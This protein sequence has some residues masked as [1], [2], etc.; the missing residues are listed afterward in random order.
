MQIIM[1][2]N[3]NKLTP[4]FQSEKSGSVSFS[5]MSEGLKTLQVT[6]ETADIFIAQDNGPD[7]LSKAEGIIELQNFR[8]DESKLSGHFDTRGDLVFRY[9]QADGRTS[10][11]GAIVSDGE[12]GSKRATGLAASLVTRLVGVV[13]HPQELVRHNIDQDGHS[14]HPHDSL[15][16]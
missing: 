1:K 15:E 11:T 10:L 3:F 5:Q 13:S 7:D 9:G 4:S 6:Q 2:V 14:D 12:G 8:Q 16:G